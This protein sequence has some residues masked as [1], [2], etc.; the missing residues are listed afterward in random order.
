MEVPVTFMGK[1]DGEPEKKSEFAQNLTVSFVMQIVV[2]PHINVFRD[3][4]YGTIT[5]AELSPADVVAEGVV[6]VDRKSHLLVADTSIDG[7]TPATIYTNC[8]VL[9]I[10]M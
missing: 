1:C 3:E 7:A 4:T 8:F 5:Q 2:R 10:A 9:T 6:V